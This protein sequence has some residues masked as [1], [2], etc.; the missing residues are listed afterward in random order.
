MIIETLQVGPIGT[1]CYIVGDE[2]T[3]VATVIDPGGSAPRVLS[4]LK[5]LGLRVEAVVATHAHFD[6]VGGVAELVR[7]TGAPFLIGE[8]ELPVLEAASESTMLYFGIH[9]DQPPSPDRLLRD[10]DT[11]EMGGGQF[12]V[13]HTPGHSPGHICLIGTEAAFVGDMVFFDS[14]G[15]ADLPGGDFDTLMRSI[16]RHLLALPDDTVLYTGHGPATTV[17]RERRSNPFLVG[18]QGRRRPQ[19]D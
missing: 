13:A 5:R 3:A 9:V 15:R 8:R 14:I 7:A 6:H 19:A 10:G 11:L 2:S 12:R 1:N 17:G 4:A 18:I 16:A